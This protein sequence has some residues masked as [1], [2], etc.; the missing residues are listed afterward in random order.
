MTPGKLSPRL[1]GERVEQLDGVVLLALEVL[2]AEVRA[3]PGADLQRALSGRRGPQR[4]AV[5]EA[6][7]ET[8]AAGAGTPTSAP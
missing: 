2:E 7:D 6:L 4:I 8:A 5:V 1:S 3:E